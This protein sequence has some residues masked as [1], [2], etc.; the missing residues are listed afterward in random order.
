[1]TNDALWSRYLAYLAE[2]YE[3][4][5]GLAD[6]IIARTPPG[7]MRLRTFAG[8]LPSTS[9]GR[10]LDRFMETVGL[11]KTFSERL[12]ALM[13]ERGVTPV[14]LYT[15]A[16]QT[17]SLFSKIKNNRDY[18]PNK[19]TVLA[20]AMAL[21]LNVDEAAELL[22]SAGY[23][24][25]ETSVIDMSVGFFLEEHEYSIDLLDEYLWEKCGLTLVNKK[26][27]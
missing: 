18:Q 19:D 9:L 20:F 17:K 8:S 15:D 16:Q 26:S 14:Q 11:K 4:G 21:H 5:D 2:H 23:A 7:T 6:T 3:P 22:R 1:M 12:L 13:D 10:R 24:F 25:C 27:K